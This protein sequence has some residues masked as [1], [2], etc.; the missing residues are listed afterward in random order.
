MIDILTNKNN[1]AIT[2]TI[3][4]LAQNLDLKVIAEG[5]ETIEQLE[6]LTAKNCFSIQGYYYSKPLEVGELAKYIERVMPIS[7]GDSRH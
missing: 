1:A 3:I 7:S 4:T 5:V 2:S 6:L